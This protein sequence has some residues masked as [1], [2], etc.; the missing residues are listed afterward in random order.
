ML[1]KAATKLKQVTRLTQETGRSFGA[2]HFRANIR[3]NAFLLPL[4]WIAVVLAAVKSLYVE[5]RFG[6]T[7]AL[8]MALINTT[9]AFHRA[10]DFTRASVAYSGSLIFL[11]HGQDPDNVVA[12]CFLAVS[13]ILL[14]SCRDS[15]IKLPYLPA[16]MILVYVLAL[17]VVGISGAKE[18]DLSVLLPELGA[19]AIAVIV[20][21]DYF[22][23]Q[24][25]VIQEFKLS[26]VLTETEARYVFD[27]VS[28]KTY[29]E[30]AFENRVAP[31]TVRNM[32]ARSIR[33]LGL[34]N[35]RELLSFAERH[36][37]S[38]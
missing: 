31:S 29:K 19:L 6:L 30:V 16:G 36:E 21:R 9:I 15:S 17:V 5:N 13:L 38:V 10:Q 12:F 1:E 22:L 37:L 11:F 24:S 18:A 34:K 2:E 3:L 33:K 4:F 23:P 27:L 7:V 20:F 28:G 35:L 8:V 32:V 25:R 26:T 14:F